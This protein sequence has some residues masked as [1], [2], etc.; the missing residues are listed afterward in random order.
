MDAAVEKGRIQGQMV[1]RVQISRKTEENS[2]S[3]NVSLVDK[4]GELPLGQHGVVKVESCVFPDVRLPEAQ[5]INYPIE[6]LITIMVLCGSES[7]GHTLQA[8][9]Y[10]TGKVI[11]WVDSGE[12]RR[13]N[14]LEIICWLCFGPYK[15]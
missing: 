1:S 15:A 14:S 3:V 10:G 2:P 5:G 4:P 9:Y 7:V 8:V 11:R 12:K 6:L 13:K